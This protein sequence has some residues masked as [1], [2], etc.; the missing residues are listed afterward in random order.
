[1]HRRLRRVTQG[2]IAL[3]ISCHSR[4]QNMGHKARE[5]LKLI[6]EANLHV[7]ERCSGRGG[8]WGYRQA[9]FLRAVKVGAP[10]VR[11]SAAGG[12]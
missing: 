3:H 5:M 1:L 7:L 2:R 4:A 12:T 8:A 9:N 10:V 6:P 11:Q